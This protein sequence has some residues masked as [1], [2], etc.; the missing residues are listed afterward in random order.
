MC[1]GPQATDGGAMGNLYQIDTSAAN[2]DAAK[3]KDGGYNQGNQLYKAHNNRFNYAFHDGHVETLKIEDTVGSA[4]GPLRV[5]VANPKG[6][7]TV[8][9]G[10]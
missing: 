8:A 1:F 9:A 3:F 2:Y 4:S 6:M 5:Q 10:D 7:W